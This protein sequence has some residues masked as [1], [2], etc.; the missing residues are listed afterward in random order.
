M[1]TKEYYELRN[2]YNQLANLY[3]LKESLVNRIQSCISRQYALQNILTDIEFYPTLGLRQ[4]TSDKF[5]E[6]KSDIVSDL[7]REKRLQK[8]LEKTLEKLIRMERLNTV[9]LTYDEVLVFPASPYF[10]DMIYDR[11]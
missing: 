6:I 9:L 10:C 1:T 4:R 7:G 5:E 11:L 3:G 2:K 8:R